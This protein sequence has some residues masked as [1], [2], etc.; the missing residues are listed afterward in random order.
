MQTELEERANGSCRDCPEINRKAKDWII[1]T[2][3]AIIRVLGV[4]Q[5][6]IVNELTPDINI[7]A[8]LV[9]QVFSIRRSIVPV[10]PIGLL[11]DL[12]ELQLLLAPDFVVSYA[13]CRKSRT[14]STRSRCRSRSR[15][16]IRIS[17]LKVS[18][19]VMRPVRPV[20][21][22]GPEALTLSMERPEGMCDGGLKTVCCPGTVYCRCRCG[23]GRTRRRRKVFGL[24]I[25]ID[26]IVAPLSRR[27]MITRHPLY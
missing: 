9:R 19:C 14:R 18:S 15:A 22:G 13:A 17:W 5:V 23:C 12:G 26:Y 7:A 10:S 6:S 11:I 24:G 27:I 3:I 2:N 25:L 20:E 4:G 8:G 21:V 16:G 1:F